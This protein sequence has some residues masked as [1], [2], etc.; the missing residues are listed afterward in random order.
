MGACRDFRKVHAARFRCSPHREVICLRLA[1]RLP[2]ITHRRRYYR[3]CL[4]LMSR[5]DIPSRKI[6]DWAT[7]GRYC[8][9]IGP[10]GHAVPEFQ[11]RIACRR[12]SGGPAAGTVGVAGLPGTAPAAALTA[13]VIVVMIAVIAVMARSA[14]VIMFMIAVSF[15]AGAARSPSIRGVPCG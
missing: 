14:V 12:T 7:A 6:R 11:F 15:C 4:V 3:R 13:A 2:G 10:I 1:L 8:G 9:R 5:C